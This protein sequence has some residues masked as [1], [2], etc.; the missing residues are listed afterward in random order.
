MVELGTLGR[1]AGG[2]VLAAMHT[3]TN[4]VVALKCTELLTSFDRCAPGSHRF[5]RCCAGVD[6]SD[7]A[8]RH[9]LIKE[10]KEFATTVIAPSQS[11]SFLIP[12]AVSDLS[13]H[14]DLLRRLLR[15]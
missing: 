3:T 5:W 12:V 7:R 8:K 1:G 9:Q 4:T 10:L 13:V 6:I 14:C 11:R 2:T 15:Q